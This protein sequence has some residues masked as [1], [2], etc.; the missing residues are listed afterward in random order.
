VLPHLDET[1][2]RLLACKGKV[3]VTGVGKSGIIAHKIAATLASTGSPAFFLN[4]LDALHGDLGSVTRDDVV[5]FVSN[6]GRTPEL[7]H[8]LPT[9]QRLKCTL[10]GLLGDVSTE[11][12]RACDLVMDVSVADEG[13]PLGL[14]PMASATA[15]TVLGD[16]IASALMAARGFTPRDFA[17]VHPA[18]TLGRR[19]PLTAADIMH[20]GAEVPILPPVATVEAA[21]VAMDKSV[22]GGVLVSS[23]AGLEGVFSDGD[24]RRLVLRGLRPDAALSEVMTQHPITVAPDATGADMLTAMESSHRKIYFL[25]VIDEQRNVVGVVRMHDIVGP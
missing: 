18:G 6:S 19:L 3:A 9:L 25:P 24:L 22:F 12:A 7:V 20:T 13:C 1:V 8:M 14:A 21:I 15:A 11:L 17:S 5:L 4:A 2:V 23:A 16:A 10:V